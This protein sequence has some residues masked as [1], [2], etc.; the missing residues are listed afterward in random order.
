MPY[1]WQRISRP[2]VLIFLHATYATCT[3][4]RHLNWT[5]ADY[6]EQLNRLDH[7]RQHADLV[8]QT[9][10][11]SPAEVLSE[12]MRFLHDVGAARRPA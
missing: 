3:L 2:D 5:Q 11:L 1:M 7:A 6:L 4:R 12:T 8:L 9:D 10:H